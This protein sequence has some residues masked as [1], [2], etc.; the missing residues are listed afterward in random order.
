MF[1]VQK[2]PSL[3]SG[4]SR[5]KNNTLG[6]ERNSYSWDPVDV[7]VCRSSLKMCDTGLDSTQHCWEL[8]Q[9]KSEGL[10]NVQGL[11]VEKEEKKED[12]VVFA[13]ISLAGFL[14]G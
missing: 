7:C 5:E 1:C 9:P 6:W 3:I 14:F 13:V 4:F 11:L 8:P 10:D 12:Y 2:V